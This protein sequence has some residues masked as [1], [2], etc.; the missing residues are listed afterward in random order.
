MVK[1]NPEV[2]RDINLV[3]FNRQV[4]DLL[5]GK[6]MHCLLSLMKSVTL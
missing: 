6:R 1:I 2:S 3:E 4:K 5:I